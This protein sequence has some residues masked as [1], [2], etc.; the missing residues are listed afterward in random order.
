MG[1]KGREGWGGKGE[2]KGRGRVAS[3]LL[4]RMDAPA[5]WPVVCYVLD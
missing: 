4:G 2:Q 1:G 3:W 5:Y